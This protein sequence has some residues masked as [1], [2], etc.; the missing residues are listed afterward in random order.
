M[1]LLLWRTPVGA[2]GIM[3]REDFRFDLVLDGEWIGTYDEEQE[4]ADAL[5]DGEV[6][7]PQWKNVD[8]STLKIPRNILEWE[9]F[10]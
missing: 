1:S 2:F 10:A 7:Q 8:I 9:Y 4:A 3:S 6:F 5:C